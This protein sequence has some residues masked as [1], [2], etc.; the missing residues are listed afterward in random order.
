MD[1]SNSNQ[2]PE[3][4]KEVQDSAATLATPD[5]GETQEK[6]ENTPPQNSSACARLLRP[7]DYEKLKATEQKLSKLNQ[8]VKVRLTRY[9]LLDAFPTL[10]LATRR[11]PR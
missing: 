3:P 8:T 10:P 1:L 7:D 6:K 11:C 2:A 5:G 4:P 9:F